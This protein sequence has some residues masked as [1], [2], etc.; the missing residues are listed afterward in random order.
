MTMDRITSSTGGRA[1]RR[2][3]PGAA[4][5]AE[6]SHARSHARF[7]AGGGR[8]RTCEFIALVC[9][10][11]LFG[12]TLA[13][14][15][16]SPGSRGL[17]GSAWLAVQHTFYGGF[18]VV[19]AVAEILGLVTAA[20]LAVLLARRAGVRRTRR[21][22]A[23]LAIAPAVAALCFLGSL[24]SYW[25]GNRP[26]NAKV[27]EWTTATLPTDWES[28]RATWENAH[29]VT[30]GLAATAFVVLAVAAV[31]RPQPLPSLPTGK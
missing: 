28:Y 9:S 3:Q 13:H 21:T 18:A 31:W 16:Q 5:S 19:G 23:R 15:L 20:T 6:R 7:A 30:A 26:V 24:V 10:A 4:P 25:L 17:S 12:L 27:A 2:R 11:V 29:A 22:A 14:V 8:A 1:P